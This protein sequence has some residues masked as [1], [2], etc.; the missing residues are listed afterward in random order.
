MK[1][2]AWGVVL[3]LRHKVARK[4]PISFS[5]LLRR[6]T[7]RVSDDVIILRYFICIHGLKKRP[8]HLV[9]LPE[10]NTHIVNEAY[11]YAT[12]M[13]TADW[14]F[15]DHFFR[16]QY[17]TNHHKNRKTFRLT[18]SSSFRTVPTVYKGFTTRLGPRGQNRSLQGLL[19][20]TKKNWVATRFFKII[21]LES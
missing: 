10:T 12:A 4:W 11:M 14:I 5:A 17:T 2:F 1:G 21:S 16:T 3:R 19:E 20:S 13:K 9:A 7:D 6:L 15:F 18:C 8:C